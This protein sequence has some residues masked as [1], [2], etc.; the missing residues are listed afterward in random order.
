MKKIWTLL[1]SGVFFFA[2]IALVTIFLKDQNLAS[3]MAALGTLV[4]ALVAA[5]TILNT[6]E[7]ARR[8]RKEDLLKEIIEWPEAIISSGFEPGGPK[9]RP[10]TSY[11]EHLRLSALELS[12]RL[13]LSEAK[14]Q[15]MSD[16][17]F[18]FFKQEKDLQKSVMEVGRLLAEHINL[19]EGVFKDEVSMTAEEIGKKREVLTQ[20]ARDAIREA[21]RVL[22]K[23]VFT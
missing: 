13:D 17:T 20:A 2:F 3:A 14:S 7:Q 12:R 9:H 23:T 21:V 6:N 19:L 22:N 10:A 1:L 15:Y 11:D 16:I 8:H 5:L 4:V 18:I